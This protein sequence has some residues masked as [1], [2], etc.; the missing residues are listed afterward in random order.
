[1]P[2]KLIGAV[3]LGLL[4]F[5]GIAQAAGIFDSA[6]AEQ[7]YAA[8]ESLL[9]RQALHS[10]GA[11]ASRI[12]R[13][14]PR[15][16]RG[17]RGPQGPVGPKGATGATGATGPAGSF[18]R[19]I[20]V[21]GP[22]VFVCGFE[23]ECSIGAAHAECPAGTHAIGGGWAG[24]FFG[25]TYFSFAAGNGWSVGVANEGQTGTTY[26]ATALCAS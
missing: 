12:G 21:S 16:I 22:D 4:V 23:F 7:D 13:R 8:R 19:I 15:G 20:Q 6:E 25:T 11:S 3:L 5:A 9:T 17:P 18:S 26:H 10:G 14:G 24:V 2:F 1:M